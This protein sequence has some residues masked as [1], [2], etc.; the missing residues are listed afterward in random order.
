MGKFSRCFVIMPFS[1][2]FENVKL[3]IESALSSHRIEM[4]I[5]DEQYFN[6]LIIDKIYDEI[7]RADLVV[8]D[9]STVAE[10]KNVKGKFHSN[11]NVCYELGFAHGLKKPFVLI[12]RSLNKTAL[13]ISGYPIIQ[14]NKDNLTSLKRDLMSAIEN[15]P[16]K[17]ILCFAEKGL[18]VRLSNILDNS[19]HKFIYED[20]SKA[21]DIVQS[22]E[23][24]DYDAI[25]YYHPKPANESD[26][27]LV[28]LVNE[29]N[30]KN[31]S[32]P[33]NIFTEDTCENGCKD[34]STVMRDNKNCRVFSNGAS[35]L[36]EWPV[37]C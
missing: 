6:K 27:N 19:A 3:A 4:K 14:Y 25:I 23:I 24:S 16:V 35:K 17:N 5:I 28:Q 37:L 7:K 9:I 20:Y 2:E 15:I 21:I 32:F 18:K 34:F 12:S 30:S 31:H 10:D 29:L 13:D 11:S 26:P 36:L 8:A 22:G 1:T 33:L